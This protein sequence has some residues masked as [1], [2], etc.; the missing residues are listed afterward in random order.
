MNTYEKYFNVFNF[1]TWTKY[2]SRIVIK[3]IILNKILLNKISYVEFKYL[4]PIKCTLRNISIV[5][6][7][8]M[9]DVSM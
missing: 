9:Q 5:L 2:I 1:K 8:I 7:N 3:K 6:H 4:S